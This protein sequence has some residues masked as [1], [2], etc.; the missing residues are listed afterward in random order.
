MIKQKIVSLE[1]YDKN[2]FYLDTNLNS[3]KLEKL[4]KY[5]IKVY[6]KEEKIA[7]RCK[8]VSSVI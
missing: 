1:T 4:F 6:K 8:C 2:E 5:I 3:H 7:K